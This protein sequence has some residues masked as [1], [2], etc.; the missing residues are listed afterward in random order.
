MVNANTTVQTEGAASTAENDTLT[1]TQRDAVLAM[2]A[3]LHGIVAPFAKP[4][5]WRP[6]PAFEACTDD[7]YETIFSRA[8]RLLTAKAVSMRADSANAVKANVETVVATFRKT[9]SERRD[10]VQTILAADPGLAES[11][12]KVPESIDIPLFSLAAA[13]ENGTSE[14]DA[15]LILRDLGYPIAYGQGKG[16]DLGPGYHRLAFAPATAKAA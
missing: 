13:F 5:N 14:K 1:N 6:L 16:K 9:L 15:V 11:G 2:L 8:K 7:E 4:N 12:V 3:T 10:K